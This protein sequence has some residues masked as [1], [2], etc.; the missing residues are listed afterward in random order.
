MPELMCHELMS[1][2][3]MSRVEAC[4]HVAAFRCTFNTVNLQGNDTGKR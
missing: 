4:E 1:H 3:Q 2:S